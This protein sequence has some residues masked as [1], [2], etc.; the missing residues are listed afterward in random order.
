MG[1]RKRGREVV[2]LADWVTRLWLPVVRS[3]LKESTFDSYR[4]NMDNHVLPRLGDVP[5]GEITPRMLTDM[6]VELLETGRL[7]GNR[8]GLSPNMSRR[9]ATS[10]A[11]WSR[12]VALWLRGGT[13]RR[14]GSDPR[15]A[16]PRAV[17]RL[18]GMS[19]L[20]VVGEQVVGSRRVFS[21]YEGDVGYRCVDVES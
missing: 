6:Y 2:E 10:T 5:L 7:N 1:K 11:L 3:Q 21:V 16:F 17:L 9:A 15:T 20:R 18:D 19:V 12:S 14:G 8:R 4:R 13:P